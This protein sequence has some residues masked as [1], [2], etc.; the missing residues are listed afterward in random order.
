MPRIEKFG[1]AIGDR[2]LFQLLQ[3]LRPLRVQ[4]ALFEY[5]LEAQEQFLETNRLENK[6]AGT[7]VDRFLVGVFTAV[8]GYHNDIDIMIFAESFGDLQVSS[9]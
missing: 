7:L 4:P 5:P 3:H 9:F 8:T 6:V 2:E 1:K